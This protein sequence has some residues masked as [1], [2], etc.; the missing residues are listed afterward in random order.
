MKTNDI[1]K[2]FEDNNNLLTTKDLMVNDINKYHI[3]KLLNEHIIERVGHG[4][5][6]LYSEINDELVLNQRN[7]LYII[8]S[9]E[10]ALY[11]HNLTDRFPHQFSVTTKSGYHLRNRELKV[12]YC[13]NEIIDMGKVK[14]LSPDGNE[15][16][17][18]DK[19]RTV[20]DIIKNK[21]RIDLQVYLQGIQNYFRYE[22]VNYNLLMKYAKELKVQNK[23][24][25]IVRLYGNP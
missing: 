24:I 21:N 12:Y 14:I 10:T 20:C 8:Y 15:I 2:M 6:G 11:L 3:R 25:D 18:Y 13:K 5:Y 7:N 22:K 17:V 4:V 16:Y 1:K 23:V 19:E 9:N